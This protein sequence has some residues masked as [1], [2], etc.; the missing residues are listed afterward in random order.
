MD[1]PCLALAQR[2]P[3]SELDPARLR[4][5]SVVVTPFNISFYE[6]VRLVGSLPLPRRVLDCDAEELLIG[7]G[8]ISVG[9]LAFYPEALS[10]NQIE[11]V[12]STLSTLADISTG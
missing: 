8:G 4:L 9:R 2:G 10:A 5:L 11:E 6:D 12:F 3:P 7:G 1:D